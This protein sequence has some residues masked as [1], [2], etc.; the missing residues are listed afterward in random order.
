MISFLL[1]KIAA[2][3]GWNW[4]KTN[5]KHFFM[6]KLWLCKHIVYNAYFSLCS[7]A[8]VIWQGQM[9]IIYCAS[10]SAKQFAD[11]TSLSFIYLNFTGWA[12]RDLLWSNIAIALY[13]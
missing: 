10:V 5:K 6:I 4:L 8:T 7:R 1:L 3:Q 9:I 11:V 12:N 13:I 2:A